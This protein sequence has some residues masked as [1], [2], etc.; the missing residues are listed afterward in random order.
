VLAGRAVFVV[1]GEKDADNLARL[2]LAATTNSAGAWG[3][4]ETPTP[5]PCGEPR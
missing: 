5:R 1:E 2:G 4:G 3:N